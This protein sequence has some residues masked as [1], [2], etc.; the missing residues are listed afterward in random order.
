MF[1]VSL[2]PHVKDIRQVFVDVHPATGRGPW[3]V[4]YCRPA[5]G[6]WSLLHTHGLT[7]A[8][9]DEVDRQLGELMESDAD[10][11]ADT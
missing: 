7:E 10:V 8:Q 11:R 1:A 6:T 4:G 2:V 5:D 3:R 9:I